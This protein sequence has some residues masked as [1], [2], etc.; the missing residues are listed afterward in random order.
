M[1]SLSALPENTLKENHIPEGWDW[2]NVNGTNYCSTTRNQHIPQ[3]WYRHYS[4][5]A[6]ADVLVLL[7]A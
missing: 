4:L 3:Y 5:R 6:S 2:R 7:T 1:Y